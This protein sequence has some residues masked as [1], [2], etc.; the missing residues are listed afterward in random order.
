[1]AGAI[2]DFLSRLAGNGGWQT[3]AGDA[4]GRHAARYVLPAG[5]HR[6]TMAFYPPLLREGRILALVGLSFILLIGLAIV[7]NSEANGGVNPF[8]GMAR[9]Q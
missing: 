6:V 7:R 9:F 1:M 4:G 2:R 5:T 8:E 3:L